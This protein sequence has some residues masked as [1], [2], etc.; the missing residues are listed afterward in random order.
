[1]LAELKRIPDL[2][3]VPEEQL[4]WLLDHAEEMEYAEGDTLFQ[5][6]DPIDWAHFIISGGFHVKI[7][8]QGQSQIVGH[9][10]APLITGNLPYS[11]A[12]SAF[13][14]ASAYL[15]SKAYRLHKSHFREMI[16]DHHELTT[17]LVH[18]MT[19]R[20]REFTK[21]QQQSEK[22]V[23]LGKLSAGLAHELNNPASALARHAETLKTEFTS[24]SK[25]VPAVAAIGLKPEH[26]DAMAQWIAQHTESPADESLSLMERSDRE[27]AIADILEEHGVEDGYEYSDMLV[28]YSVSPEELEG[29]ATKID[30]T[31]FPLVIK[32]LAGHLHMHRLVREMETASE[33]I[34]TLVDSIKSYSHM[35]RANDFEPVSLVDNINSTLT[36]L[37]HKLRKQQVQVDWQVEGT[38]PPVEARAGQLSQVWTNLID[39]AIDAMP[40]GGTLTLQ[41]NHEGEYVT[42]RVIDSG[43]GIPD[44]VMDRI[45]EPFY[46]TKGIG[47]GSGLGLDIVDKIVRDHQA[48][49]QVTSQPGRTE[50][51]LC[52]PI[53][54]T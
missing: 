5:R 1:M 19:S 32:W 31:H 46:T 17:A 11:R 7:I 54:R 20:V 36:M 15:P 37:N 35:D 8:Q 38:L 48:E 10:K 42:M 52:F 51:F 41:G 27:D 39:N 26:W 2:T 12:T 50:F 45:F 29:I 34:S 47:E 16:H 9:F 13:G 49:I 33:R 4:Q 21:T 14:V 22:M 3:E 23:A 28:G 24:L 40:D 25:D 44:D 30:D 18:N 53:R 6:G 43:A